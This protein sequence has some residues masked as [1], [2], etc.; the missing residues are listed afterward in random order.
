MS[1]IILAMIFMGAGSLQP[2]MPVDNIFKARAETP[3]IAEAITEFQDHC[4]TFML[5]KS[6]VSWLEDVKHFDGIIEASGY[7]K[8]RLTSVESDWN[9]N[10]GFTGGLYAPFS[11]ANKNFDLRLKWQGPESLSALGKSNGLECRLRV[12]LPEG[13][14]FETI[15]TEILAFDEDWQ[16]LQNPLAQG[17]FSSFA[18][19]EPEKTGYF[20]S[21]DFEQSR[22]V[23]NIN[24]EDPFTEPDV[25]P[26]HPYLITKDTPSLTFNI[27]AKSQIIEVT[28]DP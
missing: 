18:D 10:L 12:L 28:T 4:L 27:K 5:H 15:E 14:E 7:T 22:F 3:V 1:K 17:A 19:L 6:A 24:F 2:A 21:V 26:W 9:R 8:R 11:K 23:F 16:K 20:Q 25:L 13:T